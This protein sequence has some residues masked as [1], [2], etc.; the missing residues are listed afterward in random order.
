M[1]PDDLEY[2]QF[3]T[4]PPDHNILSIETRCLK[5]ITGPD[6]SKYFG[7]MTPS[8]VAGFQPDLHSPDKWPPP[9]VLLDSYSNT[10][11]RNHFLGSHT[12]FILVFIAIACVS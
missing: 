1:L 2:F 3:F 11:W 7:Q 5:L 12:G 10:S 8:V 4:M 6:D 9:M